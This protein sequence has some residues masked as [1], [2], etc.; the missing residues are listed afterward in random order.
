MLFSLDFP[1]NMKSFIQLSLVTSTIL[2]VAIE[3]QAATF[4]DNFTQ[5]VI[6]LE[7][8]PTNLVESA[9]VTAPGVLGE[10]RTIELALTV[11]DD[12][13]FASTNLFTDNNFSHSNN[14]GASSIASITYNSAGE[15][16]DV[17]LTE[18]GKSSPVISFLFACYNNT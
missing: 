3:T 12:E 15:G 18:L 13:A 14:T 16:L 11:V 6:D 8:S 5:G 17:D 10:T 7:V 9:S 4:I 1:V 2:G